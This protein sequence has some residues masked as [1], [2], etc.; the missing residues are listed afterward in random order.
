MKVRS[1]FTVAEPIKVNKTFAMFFG[2]N[3]HCSDGRNT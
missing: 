2:A 3:I 1:R